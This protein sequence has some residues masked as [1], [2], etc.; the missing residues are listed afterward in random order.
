MHEPRILGHSVHPVI[1]VSPLCL[2]SL[3]VVFDFI[4]LL[5][6]VAAFAVVSYWM[7]ATGLIAGFLTAALWWIDRVAAPRDPRSKN[8]GVAYG[9][10]N[11][12]VLL[13]YTGSWYARYNDPGT[14]ELL[15]TIFSTL[16]AGMG[17]IGS[18]LGGELFDRAS[19][20]EASRP[21]DLISLNV[22]TIDAHNVTARGAH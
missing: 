11:T 5:G 4:H 2:L 17:M 1:V 10:V 20:Y 3:A 19:A 22:T 13:L 18:W 21:D 15:A 12:A 6:G 8:S 14:P 16:G 9:I 7:M